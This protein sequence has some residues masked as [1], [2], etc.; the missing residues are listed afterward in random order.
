MSEITMPNLENVQPPVLLEPGSYDLVIR[1]VLLKNSANSGRLILTIFCDC[2]DFPE[3]EDVV[4]RVMFGME[5]DEPKT[6]TR[7]NR[8]VKA[9]L[10]RF[11]LPV[12]GSADVNDLKGQSFSAVID[13]EANEEY[14]QSNRI[15][16]IL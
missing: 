9:F 7:F 15:K 12:D 13:I 6:A 11:G 14:G 8:E 10:E 4:H 2:P 3:V 1:N 5:G 16:S